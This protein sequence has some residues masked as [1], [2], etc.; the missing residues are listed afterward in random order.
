MANS[1][2]G[3]IVRLQRQLAQV[4]KGSRVAHGASVEDA[5]ILVNDGAGSI[6]TIVGLQGDGTVGVQAVNGPPPPEPSAPIVASVIGGVSAAWD[7]LFANGAIIPM[8]WNRVEVH[9]SILAVYEP[10]PA[11]LVTTI[12][13]AQGG[14]V[15][16][17]CDTPVYVRLVART[18]SGTPSVASATVGP[19]GPSP[20]V[21]NDILDGIVTTVKLADDAVTSAKVA[22]AAIDAD[23]LANSAV[24][25]AKIGANAV[26]LGKI[27]SGAV[28]LNTLTG[29]LSD[30]ATQRYA[31]YFRDPTIWAKL[32]GSGTFLINPDATGTPSGGG[33]LTA[34]GDTQLAGTTL[35]PQDTDTLYRVMIR[36]RATAQDPSGPATIYVGLVGV[37][38]DGTT[39]VNRAGANATSMH[40]YCCTNGGSVATADGWKV[41]VGYVQ[42][43]S[44]VGVTAPA[45]PNTDPR[46]PGTTHADVRYLRPTA[47]LNFGKTTA[48]VMEVEAFTVDPL[49]TGVVNS[50]NLVTGSVTAA[51]IATD[52]VTAG[53][54]AADAITA[55][56]ITAG[57]I[58][59]AEL[60]AGA[61]T[62]TTIAADAVTAGKIAASQIAAVHM[63]ASSIETASIA[64]EA[65]NAGKIA[66]G[67]VTTAK[68]DAL[69][70]TADKIAANAIVA[71][72]IQAG[73]VDAAAIAADAI[74]GKTIT[75]GTITGSLLQTATS[76]ERVT[77]NESGANK[78][79][80]YNSAGVAIGELS[81]RGLILEGDSGALLY[82][83]P[84]GPYPNIRLTNAAKTNPAV[85]NVVEIPTGAANLGLNSGGFT[86]SGFTDMKWRTFFGQ[87]FWV[88]ERIRDSANATAVGGR[89]FLD[90]D[91]ASIGYIDTTLSTI[92]DVV[93]T[94][95][96]VKASA[97][98]VVQ[99]FVGDTS[100]TLFVQ[101]GPGHTGYMIRCWD[102]DAS[103]YKFTVDQAGNTLVKGT[104]TA[105]NIV[106]GSVTITPSAAHT[107]TST[108]ISFACTGTTFRGY[109]SAN[110]TV[111][112][113]RINAS[114][115]PG[116]GV[117]GVS[118]SSVTATSALVWVT[119]EN[120]T[121]TIVNWMV[122]GS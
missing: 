49:R 72:K 115:T 7:G 119:R 1:L 23:A 95:G 51:A 112:G 16:V 38:D 33:I 15:I 116:S 118:M 43:H 61:V 53:K 45:G 48:A 92:S 54:V 85:I 36:V 84:D 12:E 103:Q 121:A 107:P 20:V 18:A 78:L 28:N 21:A 17:P 58:N 52:A 3:E 91:S 35:I 47:W 96:Q 94:A 9:A 83:D 68:L 79:L 82:M 106:T 25:A 100:S 62:A 67:A 110:T 70:V 64:A 93:I 97:K 19:L 27:A 41:Y 24:T 99:P 32:S 40:Y 55:R 6:R 102:P 122:V 73:A 87:D 114:P 2:P 101:P 37:A 81:D 117:T 75:G 86:G 66:A 104:L 50:T 42:G 105:G 30:L 8:D 34:T 11:T 10:I 98:V 80:V 60:A 120:T 13:T 65:V 57:S 5:A 22:A 88:A 108:L 90:D 89:I 44:G 71:G 39:L 14:T 111:P 56:E 69:A 29:P 63:T 109:A 77:I 26:I 31:D 46:A 74:T 113:S 59:T 4:E 76:G